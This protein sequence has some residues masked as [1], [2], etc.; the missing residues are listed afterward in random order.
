MAT[1]AGKSKL[2]FGPF[3]LD[4]VQRELRQDGKVVKLQQQQ[5]SVLLL[6]VE[7]AGLIVSREEIH[8]RIWG[9]DTFV[10]FERGINFS[11]NQIRVALGDDAHTHQLTLKPFH[12][13][14][15][16]S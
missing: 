13:E 4:P 2:R 14:A 15:I 16:V 11:I 3:E 12:D 8:Q 5:V 10:D 7:R 1:P 6:L 9:G